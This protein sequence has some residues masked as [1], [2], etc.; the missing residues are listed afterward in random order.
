M[1]SENGICYIIGA[2]DFGD[3]EIKKKSGDYLIAGDGGFRYCLERGLKADLVV[4]DF[5]S[6][7]YRPDHPNV[8]SLK[9][10]KDETD[11]AIA[12]E[13]GIR[14][15]YKQFVLFG[16]TGGRIS[17]TMAN[18]QM[19]NELAGRGIR[20][21]LMGTGC[22]F[23]VIRDGEF[24]FGS[25]AA[26]YVSVFSLSERSEG[27]CEE[28]LKYCLDHVILRSEVPLGVSNEFIGAAG[29]ISVDKGSLLIITDDK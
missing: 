4:G 11:M 7:G 25:E 15:G 23:R 13:E 10:E 3:G 5:D 14:R 17:H 9:A 29:K 1:K 26:G 21:V 22:Q 8:I 18:I 27:V 24:R 28:G 12:V 20:C 6:L 16:G 19:M 2:G